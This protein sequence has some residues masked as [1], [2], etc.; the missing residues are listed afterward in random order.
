MQNKQNVFSFYLDEA[1]WFKEGQGVRELIGISLEPEIVIEENG[2]EVRLK[3]TVDLAGEY[4]PHQSDHKYEEAVPLQSVR[5]MDHV[6]SG[7]EGVCYFSHSFPV[8]ITVPVERISSL[9]DVLIDIESFDYELPAN[10]QLRLH[11]QLN[12]NGVEQTANAG[13]NSDTFDES[14]TLGPI[15][16][17]EE[18]KEQEKPVVPEREAPVV[19]L[20]NRNDQAIQD[21]ELEQEPQPE[22]EG[23]W[24]H[25][26]SQNFAEFFG[27]DKKEETLDVSSDSTSVWHE[28]IVEENV[29]A[30]SSYTESSVKDS[31]KKEEA[32]G[33]LDGIKQIFKHLFPNREETYSQMKMYIAQEDE[34]LASIAE[35]YEVSIH[36]LEKANDHRDEVSPGQIVYIPN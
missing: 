22:E 7:E 17:K 29:S 27:H 6:E 12:I 3:G 26:K 16:Y 32:P 31:E 23:R 10:N 33:G 28:N 20:T 25:K 34:T 14:A 21:V 36:Q 9:E 15:D 4:V 11:A 24:P 19:Q 13:A 35:K 18:R 2:D 30:S 8:E 5:T 1:I